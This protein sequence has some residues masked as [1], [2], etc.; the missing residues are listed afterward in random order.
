MTDMQQA[1]TVSGLIFGIVMMSQYGRREYNWHR[2]ALPLASTSTVGYF[3]LRGMPTSTVDWVIYGVSALVGLAFGLVATAATG[4]D[5]DDATGRAYTR[6]GAWFLTTWLAAMALRIGFVYAAEHN[7]WFHQHLGEFLAEHHIVTD[8]IA[9]FFVIMALAM[10]LTR[11]A[12]IGLRISG[13]IPV[14]VSR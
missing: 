9:P 11:V 14:R 12:L 10:V 7:T 6:C 4:L 2:V 1:L 8:A 5:R 3:Y 13:T